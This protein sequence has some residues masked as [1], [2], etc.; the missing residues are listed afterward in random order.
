MYSD[1]FGYP[2]L[3]FQFSLDDLGINGLKANST[4]VFLHFLPKTFAVTIFDDFSKVLQNFEK[5]SLMAKNE[6]NI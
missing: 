1:V 5:L 3:G 2:K 6:E 4:R